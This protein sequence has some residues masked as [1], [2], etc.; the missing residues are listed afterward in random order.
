MHVAVNDSINVEYVKLLE[1]TPGFL[2][3]F[4]FRPMEGEKKRLKRC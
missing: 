4:N 3:V 2:E 1:V